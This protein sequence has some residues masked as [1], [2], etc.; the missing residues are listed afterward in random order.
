MTTEEVKKEI[1][2]KINEIDSLK[3][4]LTE[5][6]FANQQVIEKDEYTNI[7]PGYIGGFKVVT[8]KK[9]LRFLVNNQGWL[10]SYDNYLSGVE[11]MP[12]IKNFVLINENKCL[13][14]EV[15]ELKKFIAEE[16]KKQK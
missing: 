15:E 8:E 4:E 16:L 6:I 1:V 9:T 3:K 12:C 7:H 10:S 5:M 2:S 11:E 14:K 13:K